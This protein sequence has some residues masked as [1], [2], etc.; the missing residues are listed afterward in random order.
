MASAGARLE[1]EDS[2]SI[3]YTFAPEMNQAEIVRPDGQNSAM[4]MGKVPVPG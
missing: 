3:R 1:P 2:L 4:L